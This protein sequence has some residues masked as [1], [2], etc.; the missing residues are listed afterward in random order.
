MLN[1]SIKITDI[2]H[3]K[4]EIHKCCECDC[5]TFPLCIATG[6]D[7]GFCHECFDISTYRH[8]LPDLTNIG[9][10]VK[11][12]LVPIEKVKISSR[13]IRIV[14][15]PPDGDCLYNTF[16]TALNNG[17]TVDDLR[18][19]VSRCQTYESYSVYASL[20]ESG[21]PEFK[22]IRATKTLREFKNILQYTGQRVSI[23]KYI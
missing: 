4:R 20:A 3:L 10:F 7:G 11:D 19:L 17:V 12:K 15:M 21:V 13:R 1:K 23:V 9:L 14:R 22:P 6:K 16:V 8:R 2:K 18:Y 5:E